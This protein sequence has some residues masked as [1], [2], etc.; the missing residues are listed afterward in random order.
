MSALLS[1]SLHEFTRQPAPGDL[2][3][4]VRPLRGGGRPGWWRGERDRVAEGRHSPTA[5]GPRSI[6]RAADLGADTGSAGPFTLG[7]LKVRQVTSRNTPTVVNAVFYLRNF[8]DGR[9]S[10][11]FNAVTPFGSADA[12]AQ[13]LVVQRGTLGPAAVRLD[14]SSLASQ[15]VGPPLNGVEMSYDGRAWTYLG[16]KML[17]LTPLARQNVAE[18]DG[19]LGPLADPAGT[20]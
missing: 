14:A 18:D 19:V 8:W 17:T 6:R 7:G 12:R 1:A 13:V 5:T 4:A 3:R 15:A 16:R 20:G 10:N 11:V 9:A 2:R